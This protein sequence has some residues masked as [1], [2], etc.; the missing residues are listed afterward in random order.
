[1]IKTYLLS[2]LELYKTNTFHLSGSGTAFHWR[3]DGCIPSR[4]QTSCQHCS[5]PGKAT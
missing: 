5:F 4:Q 2:F 3:R 1:M